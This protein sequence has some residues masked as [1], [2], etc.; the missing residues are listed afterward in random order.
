MRL[1]SVLS[2]AALAVGGILVTAPAQALADAPAC[3]A[4][5]TTDTVLSAD[6]TCPAGTDGLELAE[7][8]T[9][10]LG[11]HTLRGPGAGV[12]VKVQ[13]L[14]DAGVRNGTVAGWSTGIR[15]DEPEFEIDGVVTI[16]DVTFTEN[17]TGVDPSGR[18]GASGKTYE[19]SDSSFTGNHEGIGAFYGY[20]HV[21]RSLF[22]GNDS[23]V[24]L[25][26]AGVFVEDSRI[27]HNTRGLYCDESGCRVHRS[28]LADNGT[29]LDVRTFGAEV[30]DSVL[31]RNEVALGSFGAWGANVVSGSEF[32]DNGTAIDLRS[33]S[34]RILDNVFRGNGLGFTTDGSDPTWFAETL[35]RGNLFE[36]NDDA[37]FFDEIEGGPNTRLEKNTANYNRGWGIH[38]PGVVDGGG[39]KAKRN[40]NEPQCVGVVCP[41]SKPRS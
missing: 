14:G 27:E 5:L 25:I 35:V 38:A 11:G 2:G 4:V 16:D 23:A 21:V 8:V 40:G 20:A 33:S 37:I 10:D 26:T 12:G 39:N 34:G 18:W 41:G 3:G 1:T 19:V 13:V 32:L 28:T 24:S 15:N 29:A 22:T 9:L 36:R 31:T 6:L 17:G 7:G 30:V